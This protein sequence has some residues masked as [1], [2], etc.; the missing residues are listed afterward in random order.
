[1]SDEDYGFSPMERARDERDAAIAERDR[2]R[3][4]LDALRRAAVS[5]SY[6]AETIADALDDV[7]GEAHEAYL[8]E[9]R[10]VSA[11]LD[12]VLRGES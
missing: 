6:A 7:A 8:S 10:F 2:L 1:M 4:E 3:R 11:R 9:Y 5:L 12:A